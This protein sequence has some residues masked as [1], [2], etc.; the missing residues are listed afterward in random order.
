MIDAVSIP[1]AVRGEVLPGTYVVMAAGQ[2]GVGY[3][4]DEV[5]ALL[6]HEH[7]ADALIYRIVR[8]NPDGT[9]D[10]VGV[11]RDTFALEAGMIFWRAAESEARVDFESLARIAAAEPPPCRARW[12]LVRRAGEA[13]PGLWAFGCALIYP[14]EHD[15]AVAAWLSRNDYAGGTD[16]EGGVSTVTNFL[17]DAYTILDRAQFWTH[18]TPSRSLPELLATFRRVG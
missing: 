6:E 4:A 12:Q 1:H 18:A 8:T 9:T 2:T 7:F 16:V 14:A 17:H 10:L 13:A 15:P 5:A 3:S 11:S